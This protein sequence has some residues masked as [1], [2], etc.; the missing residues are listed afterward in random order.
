MTKP[1]T[2][3][4]YPHPSLAKRGENLPG[5]GVDGAEVPAELAAEWI[6]AGLATATR[7]PAKVSNARSVRSAP[8]RAPA[9]VTTPHTSKPAGPAREG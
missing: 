9:A 3:K 8:K 7:T 4:I 5:I 1:K 2:R 6:A